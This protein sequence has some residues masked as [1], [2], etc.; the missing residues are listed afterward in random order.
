[1]HELSLIEALIDELEC[2]RESNEWGKILKVNLKV[3]AV[4]QVIPEVM[5]F[6]FQ[7]ATKGTF[8]DE[9]T[10]E[11]DVVPVKWKCRNCG[12]RWSEEKATTGFCEKCGS[13]EV[14]LLSGMELEIES[15][16]V[17]D[18]NGTEN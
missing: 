17:E 18:I 6:A 5:I 12:Y 2:Q 4:R 10:L 16:E 13:V 11:L 15:L 8:L 7:V 3:G 9:A 1:M 14:D